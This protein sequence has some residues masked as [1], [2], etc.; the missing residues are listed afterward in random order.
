MEKGLVLREA[1]PDNRRQALLRLSAEGEAL[2]AQLMHPENPQAIAD[3]GRRL[4]EVEDRL[5]ELELRW[6]TLS[7]ALQELET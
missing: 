1:H 2:H 7:E 3:A 4:K 6:L 5:S